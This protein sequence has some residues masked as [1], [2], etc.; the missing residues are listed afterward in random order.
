M[1]VTRTYMHLHTGS[2]FALYRTKPTTHTHTHTHSDI[3][4][5]SFPDSNK[6]AVTYTDTNL[7]YSTHT[8]TRTQTHNTELKYT[9]Y[10]DSPV[11]LARLYSTYNA[12]M[13]TSLPM[14][15]PCRSLYTY[16]AISEKYMW[17]YTGVL[18]NNLYAYCVIGYLNS[19]LY[20]TCSMVGFPVI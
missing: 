11:C 19:K 12:Y 9:I 18:Y 10:V 3:R 2:V 1:Y 16:M 15:G 4:R 8:R 13:L 17:I 5:A 6:L 7:Q 20:D 14:T